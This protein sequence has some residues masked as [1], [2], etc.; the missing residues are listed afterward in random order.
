MLRVGLTGGIASGKTAVSSRLAVR[1]ATVI[2]ADLLAREVVGP[3]TGG[4]DAV[5]DHFGEQVLGE[6]GS[7]DRTALGALVFADAGQRRVLEAIVHPLVRAGAKELERAAP[8]DA[9]VVHDIPLLVET[10]QAGGFDVVVVVDI[11][12]E[13]QVRR[14]VEHRGLTEAEA[15]SR[16]DA[17]APRSR[18][19]KAADVVVDNS[20]TVEAL[21]AEV[22]RLWRDLLRRSGS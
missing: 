18:R 22:E 17:Q 6:D 5:V 12:V 4:L 13:Q 8:A 16:V 11:P 2:D 10:R 3:G 20:G 14:L 15:R 1:G 19:L 21:D 7:L 9:I